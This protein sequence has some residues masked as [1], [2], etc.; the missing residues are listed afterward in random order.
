MSHRGG[1]NA[2]HLVAEAAARLMAEHGIRDYALA[3]RKAARQL[4][5][6]E[7]ARLPSNDEV[8]A[9]LATRQELFEPEEQIQNLERVR[10]E[11]LEVMEVFARFEPVLTGAVAQGVVSEHSQ[12]DLEIPEETGKE[13]EQFLVNQGIEFKIRDRGA[14]CGYLIFAEPADVTIRL[15]TVDARRS[16]GGQRPR[17]SLRQLRD[18]LEVQEA[19]RGVA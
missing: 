12:I 11:A 19:I 16:T 1:E 7:G 14:Q 18:L 13:F 2:R 9:A 5:L 6:A 17:L 15:S 3:K 4:G 10:R 8:E